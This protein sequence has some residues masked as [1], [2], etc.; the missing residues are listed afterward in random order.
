MKN[1]VFAVLVA[2]A[3]LFMAAHWYRQAEDSRRRE[4]VDRVIERLEARVYLLQLK[5]NA[6]KEE[7]ELMELC[8]RLT[9]LKSLKV[10]KGGKKKQKAGINPN[11]PGKP[12]DTRL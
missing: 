10:K 12:G 9:L 7:V 11:L 6:L 8:N 5:A 4:K 2:A 1:K 3:V